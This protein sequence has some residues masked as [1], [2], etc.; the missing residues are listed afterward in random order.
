MIK[1]QLGISCM[2]SS[3]EIENKIRLTDKEAI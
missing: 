2:R 1:E 3:Y